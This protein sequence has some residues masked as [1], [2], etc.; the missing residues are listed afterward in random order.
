[1]RALFTTLITAPQPDLDKLVPAV[2]DGAVSYLRSGE[3]R[4]AAEAKTVLE[5]GERYPGDAGV[6]ASCCSIASPL[7]PARASTCPQ[8][9]SARPP[10]RRGLRGHGQLRQRLAR[11]VDAQAR[12]RARTVAQVLD[13]TPTD[14]SRIRP[15]GR[16]D[17]IELVYRT[18]APEFAVSVLQLDRDHLGHEV[19]APA[20]HDGPQILLWYRG[21]RDGACQVRSVLR[22]EKGAAA[23]VA[24]DDGPSGSS[25]N[26]RRSR[27]GP[28][29]DLRRY[30]RLDRASTG[31]GSALLVHQS[32]A[33]CRI[34]RP[35]ND[36]DGTIQR[37]SSRLK[38]RRNHSAR[39]GSALGGPE[40]LVEQVADGPVPPL[41]LAR[42]VLCRPRSPMVV[43]IQTGQVVSRRRL[44]ELARDVGIAG[45]EARRAGCSALG[46]TTSVMPWPNV[47]LKLT[48]ASPNGMMPVGKRSILS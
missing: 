25:P 48:T 18:P 17:G 19:D 14:E 1:M 22:L 33:L 9:Q 20:R 29:W 46:S 32:R 34:V 47:G 27:S 15:R 30:L 37:L 43:I 13:F 10:A 23:W 35:I 28:R 38:R 4:F 5:L 12:R 16:G 21:R 11:R 26:S 45:L 39:T 31:A 6:L 36:A 8:V 7:S 42:G 44:R 3:T 2:L 24:A 41:R 40:E